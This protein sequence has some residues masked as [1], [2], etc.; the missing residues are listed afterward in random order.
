MPSK[1][2]PQPANARKMWFAGLDLAWSA[3]NPS[4]AVVLASQGGTAK[5]VAWE[6]ELGGDQEIVGF[7]ISHLGEEPAL[8]A[9]DAPL[10]VPN[11][12]GTRKCD[13]ELSR[14][15]RERE[16]GAL[17]ANRARLGPRVRGEDLVRRLARHGFRHSPLVAARQPVRQVIE[18]YPHPAAVELFNLEKTLK[19]KARRG[20][21]LPFRQEELS[22]YRRLLLSLANCVPS[23]E[24]RAL[25]SKLNPKGVRGRALKRLEDLLDALFCAYIAYYIWWHGPAGYRCFGNLKEGYILVPHR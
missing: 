24:A 8:V 17:P 13:L 18:V 6:A 2:H 3:R 11:L 4:G 22:R 5:P 1:Q 9:I 19:Y 12:I 25:L 14:A 20:R 21:S 15:Y 23:L 10:V 7:L 16:A